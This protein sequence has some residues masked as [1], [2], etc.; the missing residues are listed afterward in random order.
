MFPTT[1]FSGTKNALDIIL[2]L[3]MC[4]NLQPDLPF[5]DVQP[6]YDFFQLLA[7]TTH[8][9][10]YISSAKR[11][12][13]KH[14][15]WIFISEL[16]LISLKISSN[17][18]LKSLEDI[19]NASLSYSFFY[20]EDRCFW[21]WIN[22]RGRVEEDIF[23]DFYVYLIDSLV[24]KN[25]CHRRFAYQIEDFFIIYDYQTQWL[26]IL[27][28]AFDRFVDRLEMIYCAEIRSKTRLFN[29]LIA[30]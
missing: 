4:I 5:G 21:K 7:R 9:N 13:L 11:K 2:V 22:R 18:A 16:T 12:W 24:T 20:F 27:I 3:I 26:L 6:V 19:G 29:R 10:Y 8:H 14:F 23:D 15:P 28:R 1:T 30:I 17:T 25:V